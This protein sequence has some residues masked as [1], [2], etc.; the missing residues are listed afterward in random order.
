MGYAV[1]IARARAGLGAVAM[2][3]L[4]RALLPFVVVQCAVTALVFAAPWTVHR[5]DAAAPVVSGTAPESEQ[6]IE[7]QMRDM[8]QQADPAEPAASATKL[9][10]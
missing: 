7:Q 2:A 5:L 4:L 9:A 6:D 3:A 1:L 8:A 10:E